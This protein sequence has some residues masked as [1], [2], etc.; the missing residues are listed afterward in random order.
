MW[1]RIFFLR[2]LQLENMKPNSN[3]FSKYLYICIF[4]VIDDFKDVK[5][6]NSH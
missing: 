3:L 6:R 4:E 2:A 1:R 5:C